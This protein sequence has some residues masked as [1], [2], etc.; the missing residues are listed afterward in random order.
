MKT[1]IKLHD[2]SVHIN[3]SKKALGVVAS[4]E[5]PLV[6]EIDLIFG[7]MVAKRVWFKDVIPDDAVKVVDNLFVCFR[8][9]RYAKTCHFADIDNGAIPEEFPLALEKRRFVPDWLNIEFKKGKLAGTFGFD[10]SMQ[11]PDE[12]AI[13]AFE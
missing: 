13:P 7:C 1:I 11:M 3:I 6:A 12:T 5:E 10:R 4:N 9:V 2:R 8:S